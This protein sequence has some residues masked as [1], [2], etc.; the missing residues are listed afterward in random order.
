[1]AK[2]AVKD[3]SRV[4][5]L[6]FDEANAI[7]KLIPEELKMTIDKALAQEPELKKMYDT[8]PTVQKVLDIS[9]RL[10]GLARHTGVHAAGVVVSDEPLDTFVPLYQPPSSNQL[11]TQ[12]DGPSV[13]LCG[14]LKM[15]FLGLSTLSIMERARQLAEKNHGVAIDLDQID[16]T[17][18]KVY[19]LFVRG[20]TKGI[21]QFE[22]GG[23]RDVLM[24]MKPNR[25]EDL[26]AANALYR[27]GPMVNIDSYVARKHGEHWKTPHPIMDEVL[28][29]TYGIMVYQEQVSRLVNRLGGIEL[30]R[31]FRLAK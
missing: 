7:S 19:G 21:F 1:K 6:N 25:I 26:I 10:E 30:K 22:S 5:G 3:V 20:E 13:E 14:L 8:N 18:Q 2:A 23:M 12:F 28:R 15:D 17:D 16:L 4:L 27:P 9:R 11:I 29:E 31:A 24:K